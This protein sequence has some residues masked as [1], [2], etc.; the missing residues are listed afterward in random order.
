M[1]ILT[2]NQHG[3]PLNYGEVFHVWSHL[4]KAKGCR[5]KYQLLSN[6]T[7]DKELKRFIQ[8]ITQN[9]IEPEIKSMDNLLRENGA[10]LP[11][12]PADKPKC[13]PNTIPSGA[14]FTDAEIASCISNDIK[15]SL[16][17]TSLIIGLST[18]E[19]VAQLFAQHHMQLVQYGGKILKLMKDKGWLVLP[20][21][22]KNDV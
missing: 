19:D 6:H 10:E 12:A 20:P 17:D 11:P 13:E 4:L 5:V 1:G 3:E 15:M 2:G 7:E 9:I 14:R 18:R 21:L 16:A 8:D 22:N